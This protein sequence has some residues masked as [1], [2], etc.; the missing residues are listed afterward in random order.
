MIFED[1][2][3]ACE[4]C[5]KGHRSS[6]C[7]HTDRPLHPIRKKGRPISQCDH[8]RSCRTSSASHS[9]CECRSKAAN[10]LQSNKCDCNNGQPCICAGPS[11][12]D[13]N[14]AM[15]PADSSEGTNLFDGSVPSSKPKP[16]RVKKKRLAHLAARVVHPP[17]PMYHQSSSI[18]ES[19]PL[20][21]NMPYDNLSY[22]HLSYPV[23]MSQQIPGPYPMQV[24]ASQY[25]NGMVQPVS[26]PMQFV[27]PMSYTAPPMT[28]LPT[29]PYT[30]VPPQ[31][32]PP[33]PRPVTVTTGTNTDPFPPKF[34]SER[35]PIV[36]SRQVPTAELNSGPDTA[37]IHLATDQST[38]DAHFDADFIESLFG[39]H[40]CSLPGVPCHCGDACDCN[41]CKT[42]TGN[43][44]KVAFAEFGRLDVGLEDFGMVNGK[45]KP[46]EHP[47]SCHGDT[48]VQEKLQRKE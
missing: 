47:A 4:T 12:I 9:K 33:R 29:D 34:W 36:P 32:D 27:G 15:T 25:S 11:K 5:I 17:P 13:Y 42:H 48:T 30:L 26:M 7:R 31:L 14:G 21:C 6:Q 28:W 43:A 3:F 46:R 8:C 19:D 10:G 38:V 16:V 35:L 22:A 18:I 24:Y 37:E 45:R 40:E 20:Q 1:V 23:D 44:D 2:K 41:G 39:V